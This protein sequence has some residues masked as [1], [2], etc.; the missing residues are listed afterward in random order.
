MIDEKKIMHIAK[1]ARLKISASEAAHYG[2]QLAKVLSHFDQISKIDTTHVEPM[3][4]PLDV[5]F[6]GPNSY[7]EDA[8]ASHFKAE[9][10]LENAPDKM[11]NLFKV[12]PVVG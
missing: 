10:M 1:L 2:D 7:R 4:S 12:P 3:V 6:F 5:D 9:E 8:A 11:G